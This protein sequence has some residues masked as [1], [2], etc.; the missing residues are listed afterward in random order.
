MRTVL[1]LLLWKWKL[2]TAALL[3]RN[4]DALFRHISTALVLTALLYTAYR[5]FYDFIFKY[6]AGLEDIG[7]L[8]IDRLLSTGFLAFFLMLAISSF[9]AAIAVMF[10]S[11]ETEYLFSTPVSDLALFTSRFV[12]TVALSSWAIMAMALPLLF[13]YARIRGFGLLEYVLVGIFVLLPFVLIAGS[14][15]T[16]LALGAVFL[17]R[18]IGLRKL[19]PLGA[20]VFAGIVYAFIAFSRPND[21]QV[22][23]NEDFRSLNLFINNF[24]LN[25]HPFT[26]NFWL[27][28]SLEALVNR[29]AGDFFL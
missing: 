5:F 11:E 8:L 21:L 12:D 13:A 14:L 26:P 9:I 28:Q 10:R 2:C 25:S 18:R 23:F 4:R 3:D 1:I 29:R 15:G 7:F 19:I 22:P 6:V 16:M 17:S 20:A 27:V 24:H